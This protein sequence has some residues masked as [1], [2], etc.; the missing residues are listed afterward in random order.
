[1]PLDV[2]AGQTVFLDSTILHYAF[3]DFPGAT[4]LC[5]DLLMR[6]V[7]EEL[8]ACVTVPVLNDAVHKVMCSEAKERF[9]Q[10]R[11]KAGQL[12]ESES[13]TGTGADLRLRSAQAD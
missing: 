13:R 9:D 11:A 6:V 1:M 10:P 5:I 3:V 7:K 8:A 4:Q 12:A 2:P